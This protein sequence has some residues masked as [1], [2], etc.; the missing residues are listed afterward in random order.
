MLQIVSHLPPPELRNH[1]A[2]PHECLRC[3]AS[4]SGWEAAKRTPGIHYTLNRYA[5]QI[6]SN[7]QITHTVTH[8]CWW[9][10][11]QA[12]GGP[13]WGFWRLRRVRIRSLGRHRV[14]RFV[15]PTPRLRQSHQLLRSWV[16]HG[17]VHRRLWRGPHEAKAERVEAIAEVAAEFVALRMHEASRSACEASVAVPRPTAKHPG[18][19]RAGAE[20]VGH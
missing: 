10:R 4:R 12:S 2:N 18:G 20:R 14:R 8:K 19:A 11:K 6:A 17:P 5:G 9:L 15:H 1:P 7:G 13:F 3:E 16:T